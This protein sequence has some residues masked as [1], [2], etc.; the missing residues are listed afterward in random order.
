MKLPTRNGAACLVLNTPGTPWSVYRSC[1]PVSCMWGSH[2][3]HHRPHTFGTA[4]DPEYAPL[5][6]GT[7]LGLVWLVLSVCYCSPLVTATLGD[8][9]PAFVRYPPPLRKIVIQRASTLVI[10]PAY[11]RPLPGKQYRLRW[12]VQ[13][14]AGRAGCLAGMH[15]LVHGT[16]SWCLAHAVVC[17]DGWHVDR[18]PSPN[19]SGTSV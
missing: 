15:K 13:E 18:E 5:V 1:C 6:H 17:R 3:D 8:N 9:R 14:W 7:F 19:V 10:N 11:R 2:G 16:D 12:L 4:D